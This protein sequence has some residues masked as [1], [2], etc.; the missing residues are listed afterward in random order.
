MKLKFFYIEVLPSVLAGD[1]NVDDDKLQSDDIDF[2][3]E[4]PKR[5][6]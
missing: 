6:S 2:D 3:I 1:N 5:S 4:G